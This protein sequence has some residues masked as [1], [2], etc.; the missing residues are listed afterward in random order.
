[1][2]P[3]SP[4]ACL[5]ARNN[6]SKHIGHLSSDPQKYAEVVCDTTVVISNLLLSS[7]KGVRAVAASAL[8]S[9]LEQDEGNA[10]SETPASDEVVSSSSSSSTTGSGQY[11]TQTFFQR[12]GCISIIVGALQDFA[13]KLSEQSLNHPVRMSLEQEAEVLPLLKL[14]NELAKNVDNARSLIEEGAP[15]VVNCLSKY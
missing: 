4:A 2:I 9:M 1:M 6:P 7:S 14:V 3:A 11:S 10:S 8:L 12:S 5:R 15:C 13:W